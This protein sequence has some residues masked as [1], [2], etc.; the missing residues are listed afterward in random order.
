[1][2]HYLESSWPLLLQIFLRLYFLFLPLLVFWYCSHTP[3][4]DCNSCNLFPLSL[5]PC[6]LWLFLFFLRWNRKAGESWNSLPQAR[7]ILQYCPLTVFP[8]QSRPLW[9]RRFWK[10]FLL[11]TLPL[12]LPKPPRDFSQILKL[13][14]WWRSWRKSPQ[15]CVVLP[16][17]AA[18]PSEIS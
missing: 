1:M 8:L 13:R 11:V 15:M 6:W 10:G 2:I 12:P 5:V 4:S 3:S 14:I 18:Y 16:L 17:I 9:L 7:I